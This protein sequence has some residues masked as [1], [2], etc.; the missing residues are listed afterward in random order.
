MLQPIRR[1]RVPFACIQ[2]QFQLSERR[3]RPCLKLQ[4]RRRIAVE[5]KPSE[6]WE[7]RGASYHDPFRQDALDPQVQAD[8]R[9]QP[10]PNTG[11]VFLE[12]LLHPDVQL[13]EAMEMAGP[14]WNSREGESISQIKQLEVAKVPNLIVPVC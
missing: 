14:P 13:T 2:D 8:E 11:N 10:C 1:Y 9:R 5:V 3:L 12:Y 6:N 7:S 4:E